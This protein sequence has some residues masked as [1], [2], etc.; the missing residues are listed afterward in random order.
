ML[1]SKSDTSAAG[2]DQIIWPAPSGVSNLSRRIVEWMRSERLLIAVLVSAFA[3]RL[4]LADRNS[5]W[6]DELSSVTVH[7]AWNESLADLGRTLAERTVYPPVYFATLFEWM[8]WFGDSEVATR[9]LSNIYV[10]VAGLFLYLTLRM[11]FSRRIALTSVIAFNL[12]HAPMYHGLETRPYALNILLV[13]LSSYLLLRL[14]RTST[15]RGWKHA[16]ISPIGATFT[17]TNAILLLTHYYNTFFWVAQGIAACTFVLWELRPHRWLRGIGVVL[18]LYGLQAA[19]FLGAWGRE[20]LDAVDRQAESNIID[21]AAELPNPFSVLLD[22]VVLPNID[23]PTFIGWLAIALTVGVAIGAI[24]ALRRPAALGLERLRAW[25]TLYLFMWLLLPFLVV[26]LAFLGAGIARYSDRYFVFSVVPLAPLIVLVIEEVTRFIR[27]VIHRFRIPKGRD[28][29]SQQ[30]WAILVAI[31]VIGTMIL[32]GTVEAVSGPRA[33]WRGTARAVVDIIESNPDA[34]YAVYETSF[35]EYSL[36]DYY[37]ARYSDEVRVMGMISRAHERQ[38][39]GFSF[40]R[41]S[42]AI[43]RK[44]FLIVP[45]IHHKTSDFPIALA[46]LMDLYDVHHWQLDSDGRGI[47]IFSVSEGH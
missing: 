9:L 45:F 8:R 30:G 34:S 42:D 24:A 46:R 15:D 33:D 17:I 21:G 37:L 12:M 36:L 6:L 5:Y 3:A 40:E 16:L 20:A 10:T 7:G 44:D 14:L 4:L 26:Y 23:A 29:Y 11:G 32:P 38:G 18:G 19:I 31:V 25:V 2:P 41:N 43:G 35:R 13:T 27:T 1:T 39:G 28:G 22:S 47:V